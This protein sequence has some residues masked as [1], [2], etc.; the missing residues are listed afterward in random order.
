MIIIG[1]PPINGPAYGIKLVSAANIPNTT[2]VNITNT[3]PAWK[4]SIVVA[5]SW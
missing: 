1:I 4:E 5:P 3:P 2:I